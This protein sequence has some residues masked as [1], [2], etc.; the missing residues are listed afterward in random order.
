MKIFSSIYNFMLSG[1]CLGSKT[2]QLKDLY[3]IRADASAFKARS[4][5]LAERYQTL[6]GECPQYWFSSPGRAEII[7]NH[8]DHNHGKVIVAAISCD[9]LAAVG[10]RDDGMICIYSE[11]FEPV[12]FCVTDTGVDPAEQG[13]SIALARGVVKKIR[14]KGFEPGGFTAVCNSTVFRGA[15]V[16]SS[17]AYELLVC[18]ILNELYLGG[19]LSAVEKA[20]ISQYA[21]N[22]Y[23][24][25]PC[26]LLDQCGISFGGI[27]AIDFA[28][29][30]SPIVEEVAFDLSQY[31]LSLCITDTKGSHADLT[32]DYAAV[33][34]EMESVAQAM[35][36]GVLRETTF[37]A[38]L[39]KLPELYRSDAVNDRALLRA[40]HFYEENA[41][42]DD[43]VKALE[44]KDF[45][46]FKQIIIDSGRSSYMYNQNVFTPKDPLD[47]KLSLALAL[48]EYLLAG[49]GAWR[50]HGGGFAGTIQAFAPNDMLQTYKTE[51]ERVFGAGSCH[52][53]SI[54]PCGGVRVL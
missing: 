38:F 7:G 11:G 16:S 25:K 44:E 30:A 6:T 42:V 33:R 40:Y 54:R 27:R 18:E 23:F 49:K 39:E 28:D 5:A 35:D 51:M 50:V 4:D 20:V 12:S 53:L 47:Q 26:G 15:G 48:S 21:E 8:T 19:A 14:D 9:I 45:D 34:G 2:M 13:Q 24:G 10:K 29:P 36:C 41:R 37:A 43:A 1:N 52:V 22:V 32:D 31:G 3:G 17:A 46:A